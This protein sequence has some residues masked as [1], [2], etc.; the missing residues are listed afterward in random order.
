MKMI[1]LMG[2]PASGKST[3][4]YQHF[5]EFV[6]VNQDVLGTREN[7]IKM[8]REWLEE[9][10]RNRPNLVICIDRTNIN[11]QQRKHWINLAEEYGIEDIQCIYF[12]STPEKCLERMKNRKDHPTIPENTPEQ[13]QIKIIN[14]FYKSLQEPSFEEGFTSINTLHIDNLIECQS[15]GNN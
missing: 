8:A 14:R 13:K 6:R 12:K 15:S 7:C 4:C 10:K 2:L 3:W 9:G 5:M 1:I 11:K